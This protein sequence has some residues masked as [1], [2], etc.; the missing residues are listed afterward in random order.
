[1]YLLENERVLSKY[2][3]KQNNLNPQNKCVDPAIE[4]EANGHYGF[5]F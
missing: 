1:M 2:K 4:S 3:K 5:R